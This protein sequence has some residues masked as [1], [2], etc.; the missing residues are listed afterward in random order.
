M[1]PALSQ[2]FSRGAAVAHRGTD[3]IRRETIPE[4]SR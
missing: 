3:H 4:V 1:T 2:K